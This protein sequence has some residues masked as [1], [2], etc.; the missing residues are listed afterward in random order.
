M[1]DAAVQALIQAAVQDA[2]AQQQVAAAA[3]AAAAAPPPPV[4]PVA[5]FALTPGLMNEQAPWDYSTTAGLKLFFASTKGLEPKFKG[6]QTGLKVFLRALSIKAQNFGWDHMIL[7]IPDSTL[8][9]GLP[10]PVNRDLLMQYRLLS[11][12]D[13]CTRAAT[14]VGQNSRAAQASR[15]LAQCITDS[16]G[17]AITLKLLV[18]S[19]KYTVNGVEDGPSMLKT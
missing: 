1:D 11:I 4:P 15:Q 16:L 12:E 5:V 13:V 18:R 9:L 3:A 2:L 10:T 7:R 8:T 19:S 6:A 17:D 14:W